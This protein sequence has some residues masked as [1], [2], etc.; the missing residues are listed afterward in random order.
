MPI[1]Q[2]KHPKTGEIIEKFQSPKDY[3]KPLVLEDGTK[4]TRVICSGISVQDDFKIR[5]NGDPKKEAEYSKKV[6]D[7]ERARKKRKAL[8]GDDA[9]VSKSSEANKSKTFHRS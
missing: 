3:Q 4:C 2:Y 1:Y 9:S 7:P 5:L 8:F 6:K